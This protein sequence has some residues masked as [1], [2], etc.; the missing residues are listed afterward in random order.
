LSTLEHGSTGATTAMTAAIDEALNAQGAL[1]NLVPAA[2]AERLLAAD[3]RATRRRYDEDDVDPCNRRDL[4][5]AA[6]GVALG[7][8]ALGPGAPAAAREVDPELPAHWTSLLR[9]L[10][11]HDELFGPR[12]V[13]DTVQRELRLIAEHR[14]IARGEL[15]TAL[16]RVE[17]RW[18]DLAA[19]LSED[20]GQSRARDTWANRALRLAQE[21]GYS[22]MAAFARG[23]QS[24][25]ASDGRRAAALAEDALRVRGASAQT[26]AWCLRQ[27]A[28][29]HAIAGDASACERRL[30]E[31]HSLLDDESP[32]PPWAGEYRVAHAGTV[33]A[34]ARCWAVLRDPAKAIGFYEDALRDWPRGEARDGGLHRARMALACAA[35]GELDRAQAEGKR[36][37]AIAKQTKSATATGE[38]RRL[39]AAL[40]A[41]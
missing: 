29:G 25:R 41:A 9:L 14:Q 11:R 22:D 23:R 34:E 4:L 7:A 39:G 12:E 27:A 10:G 15:R 8:N 38:L 37:L 18:A 17:S 35:A 3:A 36:A 2:I 26:R 19:W 28:L 6:A 13:L 5:D 16:M 31:A 24:E 30:A 20:S 32:A 1:L 21:A 33:A 40:R